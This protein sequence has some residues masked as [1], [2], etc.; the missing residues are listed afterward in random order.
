MNKIITVL[1]GQ[2]LP[3][4]AIQHAGDLAAWPVIASLNSLSMTDIIAAG[5][6]LLIPLP[7]VKSISDEFLRKAYQ[8]ASGDEILEGI[9]YWAI[10]YEFVVS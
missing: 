2:T 7:I 6:K 4:I 3:D 9:D 5:D 1:P 10:L 8:P